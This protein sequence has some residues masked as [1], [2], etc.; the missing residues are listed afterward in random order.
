MN[1]RN[2]YLN[3]ETVHLMKISEKIR[4][5]EVIMTSISKYTTGIKSFLLFAL[6]S[7]AFLSKLERK[8]LALLIYKLKTSFKQEIS[9]W[10]P[11]TAAQCLMLFSRSPFHRH[12]TLYFVYRIRYSVVVSRQIGV[13]HCITSLLTLAAAFCTNT[14]D[15]VSQFLSCSC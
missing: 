13:H 10:L 12:E 15:S 6:P 4:R 5:F 3:Y 7:N 8:M 11:S 1:A 9:V 14:G 2:D